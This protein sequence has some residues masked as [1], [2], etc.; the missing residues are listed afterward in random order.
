MRLPVARDSARLTK[1]A[2]RTFFEA[3]REHLHAKVGGHGTGERVEVGAIPFVQ[4]FGRVPWM[5]ADTVTT[6]AVHC[7]RVSPSARYRDA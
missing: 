4:R 1:V 6:P 3:I 2:R 7:L 5:G